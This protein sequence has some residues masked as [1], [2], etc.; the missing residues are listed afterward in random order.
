VVR[1]IQFLKP[2][3]V[4]ILSERRTLRPHGLEGGLPGK[5]G[6]NLYLPGYRGWEQGAL[7]GGEGEGEGE[8]AQ[9]IDLGGKATFLVEAGDALEILTPGGGGYGRR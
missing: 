4:S 5:R 3:T 8:G 2:L 1:V 9:E 7:K 6:R